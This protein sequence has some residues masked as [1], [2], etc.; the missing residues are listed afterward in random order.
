VAVLLLD[1]DG[2]KQINDSFGHEAGDQVLIAV[3]QRLRG[4]LRPAD[5]VARL[6][7]DEFTILL[8]DIT[9]LAEATRVAER[10]AG[11]LRTSFMVEG[12]ETTVSTSIGIAVNEP[13]DLDPSDMLRNADRAMYEAKSR[14]SG[15]YAVFGKGSPA[16]GRRRQMDTEVDVRR[17][18]I[19]RSGDRDVENGSESSG[20]LASRPD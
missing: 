6:G 16:H 7:G 18:T 3:S 2:F 11:S 13:R 10:I 5:T 1:L 9:D 20:P 17:P 8:E 14:G 15:Q 12:H 4:C 19:T